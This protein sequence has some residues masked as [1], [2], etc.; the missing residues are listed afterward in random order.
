M[1]VSF[2]LVSLMG[3]L[4]VAGIA[5]DEPSTAAGDSTA[6]P[7]LK[8]AVVKV[9]VTLNDLRDARL[10]ISRVR[11]AAANLYDEVTR[12]QVTMSYNP[13]FVGTTVIMTPTASFSG[14]FL[15]P[16][17]KWVDASMA[18]IGPIIKLFK[19]D[20]DAAIESNRRTEVS[21]SARKELDP[22]RDEAFAA[23]NSSFDLYKQLESLTGGPSYDNNSI[24]SVTKELDKQME[25]LDRSLKKGIAVLQKEA[26]SSRKAST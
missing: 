11:K 7:M 19:E 22:L 3:T 16:R 25:Q 24:A 23:V 2:L 4:Q 5:A 17:K 13:N 20:V 9:E 8:G 6:A 12:Q 15:P 26:K 18:E 21:E 1:V 14:R 10:S